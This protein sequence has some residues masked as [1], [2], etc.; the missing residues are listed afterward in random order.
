[1]KNHILRYSFLFLIA[2]G[3]TFHPIVGQDEES[4]Q[5]SEELIV[6]L[7][8]FEVT[9]SGEEG[10]I[11]EQANTGTIIA[12]DRDLIP[13]LTS[14]VTDDMIEDMRL[15]NPAD[16]SQQIEGVSINSNP[17]QTDSARDDSGSFRVRGFVSE[18][19]YNGFQTGGRILSTNGLGRVEVSRGP[20]SVLY[21][22]APAGGIIN[23]VPKSPQFKSHARVTAGAGSNGWRKFSV[24]VGG[25]INT[26][27]GDLAVR[28]GGGSLEYEREQIFF[29]TE[30][31]DFYGSLKWRFNDRI[32]LDIQ[33]EFLDLGITPSRT[34]AFV[35]LG[36]GTSRV[37]DPFNRFRNDRNFTYSGPHS[38]IDK[39][40]FN[41]TGYLSI[42][43]ADS[44]TLRL[45]GLYTTQK[46]TGSTL[47]SSFGLGTSQSVNATY[48]FTD[49]YTRSRAY[50]I[51]LLHQGNLSGIEINT[52]IGFEQHTENGDVFE[53]RTDNSVTPII[54]D[55]PFTRLPLAS[56]FPPPP[57]LSAFTDLRDNDKSALDWTNIRLTQF[58]S[59][60][61]GNATLMWG[62]AYGDGDTLFTDGVNNTT[63]SSEGSDTTYT[64]GGTYAIYKGDA[65][66]FL[67][68]FTLFGNYS[69][70]FEIQAGNQQN[71]SDFDGF[72]TVE[73][74]TE[75]TLNIPSNAIEPQTG[76]G[77][78]VGGR[79]EMLNGKLNFS[80]AYFNQTRKNIARQFFVRESRVEGELSENV[81]AVFFLAAG[82]ENSEGFEL[83]YD[84]HPTNNFVLTG[85][86]IFSD[87]VVVD[88]PEAPD[89]IGFGLV[90]S[91][92][93]MVNFWGL[94]DFSQD[95]PLA[96][97]SM[98]IG[99]SYNSETRLRPE[100]NNR[101]RLS[102]DYTMMRL[103]LR[104]TFP[105]FG[106]EHSFNLNVDNLTDKEYVA[107]DGYLSEPRLW[108]LTYSLNF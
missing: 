107:E 88:N 47:G 95:G 63:S 29:Q 43:F 70:S 69:S 21:G 4:T 67:N 80:A 68:K 46:S 90:R 39:D 76:S 96:G 50:K 25:P 33:S 41:N 48:S 87:G 56:D 1:M 17:I 61:E 6:E 22:Q 105:A 31:N 28:L 91:P 18:P 58:I 53:S 49:V 71:P 97:L 81:I 85:G 64:V 106:L 52:I 98:G 86:A 51:D 74:L 15:D 26:E 65:D 5:N 78:E 3:M 35:S 79:F 57:P 23:W 14:V 89:E 10:Y 12:I 104:Y 30:L 102:D 7:S 103:L 100:V 72:A 9:V 82:E 60:G 34:L 16:I 59:G 99:A 101:F 73:E 45:G 94:Y 8:P 24:D 11:T 2:L 42:K 108:K 32:T 36:S 40:T 37:T 38:R 92:E 19:L 93:T 13:F 55:I 20:N 27:M 44:L 84:W 75:F 62:I 54:V 83:S 66:S 77:Y